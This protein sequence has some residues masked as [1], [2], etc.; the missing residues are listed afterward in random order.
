MSLKR[1]STQKPL[2][3]IISPDAFTPRGNGDVPVEATTEY[4]I[5]IH[6]RFPSWGLS[7]K[8]KL[9]DSVLRNYPMHGI[10]AVRR[11]VNRGLDIEEYYDI[12][13]GQTRMTVLQEYYMDKF[14][15]EVGE[16]SIGNGRKFSE[17]TPSLTYAFV[18]YEVTLNILDGRQATDDNIGDIFG[19]LNS[20]KP[21]GDNDK[22][23]SRMTTPIMKR[24]ETIKVHPELRDDFS[25]FI[26]AIGSG[27]TRTGLSD[28][29]GAVLSI[30]T[31]YA[32]KGGRACIN[33]SYE[34]NHRYLGTDITIEQYNDVIKFFKTYF[35]ML[36]LVFDTITRKPRKR[37]G[38]LSGVLGVS[39]CSWITHGYIHPAIGIY[40][41]NLVNDPKY[42]PVTFREL[43]KGD[44]RNCQGESIYRR[45]GKIIAQWEFDSVNNSDE[46]NTSIAIIPETSTVNIGEEDE[47][48]ELT[49]SSNEGE[50]EEELYV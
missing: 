18:N 25:R 46:E 20:G 7:K 34:L 24:L 28:F 17:L 49:I 37:Y 16:N 12:E 19:R 8:Q 13:D 3:S 38:K 22:F 32:E 4:R 31:K 5:P 15:C 2:A 44:I 40:T 50:E 47:D 23:Y 27:K 29:V 41:R 33:T 1:T 45:L 30:A 21:L 9:V 42:E 10:I 35:E 11:M 36:H 43:T 14:A 26:G 6:Q 39:I 48:D